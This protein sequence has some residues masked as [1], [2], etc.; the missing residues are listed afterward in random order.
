MKVMKLIP[1]KQVM[2]VIQVMKENQTEINRMKGKIINQVD[3]IF[4]CTLSVGR[5]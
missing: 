2:K 5:R 3:S 4:Q 1:V